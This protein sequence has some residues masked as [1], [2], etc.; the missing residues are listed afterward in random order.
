MTTAEREH[1]LLAEIA[2]EYEKSGYRV[3]LRPRATDLPDFL[4]GFQPDLLAMSEGENVIVEVKARNR[5]SHEPE[6]SALQAALSQRPGW[7]FELV[8][9]GAPSEDRPPLDP[10]Q[11]TTLLDEVDHL[12]QLGH[13]LAAFL[14]LWSATE[15]L[16]RLAAGRAGVG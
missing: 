11:I 1:Q 7:R 4:T 2:A 14:L 13:S 12:Q 5:L 3:K 8:I 16:L 9:E 15:G 10:S 6:I